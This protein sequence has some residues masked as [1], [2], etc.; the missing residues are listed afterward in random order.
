MSAINLGLGVGFHPD[1]N[2]KDYHADVLC[3]APTL[4]CSIAKV[5]VDES[6]VHCWAAHPRLGN[7]RH[8]ETTPAMEFGSA[9]HALC[10][11]KGADLVVVEADNWMTKA[12]KEERENA[13]ESGKIPI[14]ARKHAI[15]LEQ[16]AAFNRQ[17]IEFGL[18]DSFMAAKSEVVAIYD[19]G[20]V[21]CRAMMDKLLIDE[22]RKS[23]TIYD[24]KTT[25]SANPRGLSRLVFN[26]HYDMQDRSYTRGVEV[27][28]SDLAGRIEFLFLFLETEYPYCLTPYRLCGEQQMLGTSKWSRA[29]QMWEACLKANSWPA[30]TKEI[31]KGEAPSFALNAE[32]GANPIMP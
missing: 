29:W 24:L 11:G 9:A 2:E 3:E 1:I 12:A 32:M 16:R 27:L 20:S 30:Y 7:K 25:D 5:L 6:P 10:L 17:L 15:A 19:D 18:H 22:N 13:R 26:M 28:R 31:V 4:S 14:L 8:K 23:A 21:R